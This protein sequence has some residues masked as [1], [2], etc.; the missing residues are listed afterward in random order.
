MTDC[1]EPQLFI[2]HHRQLRALQLDHQAWF[3]LADTARLMGKAL[4]ERALRKLDHDQHRIAWLK[5]DGR[6]SKQFLI[7]ESALFALL[8]HHY[9][10]ENR[11]LR[12]WLTHEVLPTL[13]MSHGAF[14]A[15]AIW[16][17]GSDHTWKGWLA[18]VSRPVHAMCR[19]IRSR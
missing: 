19:F 2:R 10:P 3:C 6:W 16:S 12:R 18:S 13:R 9:V 4:D 1:F 14:C 11:A 8:V 5:S 15:S 17:E 7:S